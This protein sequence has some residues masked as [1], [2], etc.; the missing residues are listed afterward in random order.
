MS[1]RNG[2]A[3]R[4]E[5]CVWLKARPAKVWQAIT[6]PRHLKRWYTTPE[7]LELKKGG[8][9]DF[10][11]FPGE[12]L[13]VKSEKKLVET[14]TFDSKER[15]SRMTFELEAC[16]KFT[17]LTVVHDRFG[18]HAKIHGYWVGGWPFILCN[19]KTYIETGAPMW[20]TSF[21]GSAD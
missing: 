10:V 4:I 14:H 13:E 2:K 15:P 9:W 3:L 8:R 12:V 18:K 16:G 21:K 17:T 7:K 1:G 6:A 19:L 20:E 5:Q 11:G